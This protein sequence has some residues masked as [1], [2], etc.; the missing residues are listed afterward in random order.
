MY[1]TDMSFAEEEHTDTGLADTAADGI[2]QFFVKDRFLEWKLSAV[3]TACFC[4]LG[5]KRILI[6]TDTHRRKLQSDIKNR[7]VYKD[8]SVQFP[9]IVVRGTSIVTLS[10]G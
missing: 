8:I 9:V 3:V 7:I 2:W 5:V 4:E 10:V 1:F 6:N